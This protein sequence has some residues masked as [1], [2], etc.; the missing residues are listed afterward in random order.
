MSNEQFPSRS[1][2]ALALEWARKVKP[3]I[4]KYEV[5]APPELR[6]RAFESDADYRTRA[7]ELK[8]AGVPGADAN[9]R[10]S[11]HALWSVLVEICT[12]YGVEGYYAWTTQATIAARARLSLRTVKRAVARLRHVGVIATQPVIDPKTGAQVCTYYFLPQ[13]DPRSVPAPGTAYRHDATVPVDP[14]W[15]IY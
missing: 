11:A 4:E 10:V 5:R 9:E 12:F 1:V 3:A 8:R 14:E 13:H 15:L 2:R 7:E 6:H